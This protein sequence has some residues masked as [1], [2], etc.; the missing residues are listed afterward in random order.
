MAEH[1]IALNGISLC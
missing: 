1:I